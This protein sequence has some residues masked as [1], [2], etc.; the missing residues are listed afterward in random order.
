[1]YLHANH[2]AIGVLAV[3]AWTRAAGAADQQFL[4]PAQTTWR[5][6]TLTR[7]ITENNQ[8][9]AGKE[10]CGDLARDMSY[11]NNTCMLPLPT[12][13]D[14]I[15]INRKSAASMLGIP[16]HASLC[17]A[18]VEV[19]FGKRTVR[20]KIVDECPECISNHLDLHCSLFW[21]LVEQSGASPTYDGGGR[22]KGAQWRVV[23]CDVSG[24]RKYAFKS[25][26][27]TGAWCAIQVRNH[28]EII[29]KL[30]L[31]QFRSSEWREGVLDDN[32]FFEFDNLVHGARYN[33]RIDGQVLD[34]FDLPWGEVKNAPNEV[35]FEVA[36]D[37]AFEPTQRPESS[38]TQQESQK[39]QGASPTATCPDI[40]PTRDHSCAEQKSW[41]KC[42]EAWMKDFCKMTCGRCDQPQPI[43]S[44][45]GT[46]ATQP[47]GNAAGASHAGPSGG[48]SDGDD[49]FYEDEAKARHGV[50][51]STG[52][53]PSRPSLLAL[54]ALAMAFVARRTRK[55]S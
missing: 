44:P 46:T 8:S 29:S 37:N 31:Q 34:S 13:K 27:G 32:G 33:V 53:N 2:L 30:D 7:R 10:Y 24:K 20:G 55:H 41:N 36:G 25:G 19:K 5:E 15:G 3:L 12:G 18:C 23:A 51:C 42:N 52:L 17:N 47:A 16:L 21:D 48:A 22:L 40:P 26:C 9:H 38:P 39:P 54:A 45:A 4:A 1:M 14:V 50:A 35:E 11:V 6:A 43:A 28:P 49:E